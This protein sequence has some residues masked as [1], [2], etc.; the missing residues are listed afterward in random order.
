MWFLKSINSFYCR[1]LE[2]NA[3]AGSYKWRRQE[4]ESRELDMAK[5]LEDN[6][7]I[8]ESDEFESLGLPNDYYIPA[9]HIYFNDDLTVD[10]WVTGS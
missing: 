7:I 8:D 1:Y 2:I 4:G 9:L 10:E 3:H 6:G 5:T